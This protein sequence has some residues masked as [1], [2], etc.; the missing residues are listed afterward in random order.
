MNNGSYIAKARSHALAHMIRGMVQ[1][2]C[3][4]SSSSFRCVQQTT[5]PPVFNTLLHEYARGAAH[6]TVLVLE[7]EV[8]EPCL[9]SVCEITDRTYIV[10]KHEMTWMGPLMTT[11]LRVYLACPHFDHAL[12]LLAVIAIMT[13]LLPAGFGAFGRSGVRADRR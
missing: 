3:C 4:P 11:L 6:G 12:F 8:L 10:H 5:G 13:R 9:G 2:P 7:S 1:I